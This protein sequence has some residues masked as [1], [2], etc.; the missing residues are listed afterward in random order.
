M[1]LLQRHCRAPLQG[2]YEGRVPT[3]APEIQGGFLKKLK[4]WPESPAGALKRNISQAR[5]WLPKKGIKGFK[6]DFSEFTVFTFFGRF[7]P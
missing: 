6:P 4:D 2:L 1:E 7:G 3:R 5:H